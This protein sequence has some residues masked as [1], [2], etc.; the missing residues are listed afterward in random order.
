MFHFSKD[1]LDY[2]QPL[3]V[4]RMTPLKIEHFVVQFIRVSGEDMTPS[5]Q[6][7]EEVRMSEGGSCLACVGI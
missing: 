7:M 4:S 1:L 3:L 2:L 6:I 5:L